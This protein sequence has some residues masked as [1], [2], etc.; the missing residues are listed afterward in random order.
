MPQSGQDVADD[1]DARLVVLG[2]D[3]T[4]S[5]EPGCAAEVAAKAIMQSRGSAP[6]LYRN[7]LAFLAPDKTRLQDLDEAVRR[8]LAWESILSEK[9]TLDLSPHQVKQAESQKASGERRYGPAA[10]DVPVAVGP[11]AGYAASGGRVAER[12]PFWA[13]RVGRACE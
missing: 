4:Y 10:G 11:R 2:L 6:R 3:H 12:A 13:G 5:R 7:S 8:Y 1:L 9:E